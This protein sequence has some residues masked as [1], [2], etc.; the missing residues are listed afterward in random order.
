MVAEVLEWAGVLTCQN[1]F[2][3]I[4]VREGEVFGRWASRW[5]MIRMSNAYVFRDPLQPVAGVPVAERQE[6]SGS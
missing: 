2:A 4:Q 3:R 5:R 1:R 6:G